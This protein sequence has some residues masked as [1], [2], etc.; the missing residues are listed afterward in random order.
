MWKVFRRLSC[1][2][3]VVHVSLPYS[4]VLMT[5]PLYSAIL[6]HQ[7]LKFALGVGCYC[8][9]VSKPHVRILWSWL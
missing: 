6:V 8:R 4:S 2:A 9:I 3:Y 5:Q 1:L 7:G